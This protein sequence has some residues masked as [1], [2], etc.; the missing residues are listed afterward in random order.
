MY[1][2]SF[3]FTFLLSFFFFYKFL[4]FIL[5]YLIFLISF[6]FSIFH[7]SSRYSLSL[8]RRPPHFISFH[9]IPRF[10][11]LSFPFEDRKRM[12]ADA[13]R[14]SL[15]L[16]SQSKEATMQMSSIRNSK[17]GKLRM[18]SGRRE[19]GLC[20]SSRVEAGRERER[21]KR[22]STRSPSHSKQCCIT[23]YL[24]SGSAT[25]K[26]ARRL[27]TQTTPSPLTVN[28]TLANP[29]SEPS[30]HFSAS[31]LPSSTSQNS[32]IYYR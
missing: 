8:S 3:Y 29:L 17:G 10:I 28:L 7:F 22:S 15:S 26:W 24:K 32:S 1:V 2:P 12:K 6:Y 25:R 27:P 21:G 19:N 9:V 5:F 18:E 4:L 30:F 16:S 14:F 31:F 23:I 13:F 20:E 11:F